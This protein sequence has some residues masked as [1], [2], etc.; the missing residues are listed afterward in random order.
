MIPNYVSFTEYN[1]YE[2]MSIELKVKFI[3]IE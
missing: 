3:A 1:E 2:M